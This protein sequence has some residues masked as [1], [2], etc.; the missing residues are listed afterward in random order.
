M[1]IKLKDTTLNDLDVLFDFQTDGE[2]NYL[3]AFTAENPEDKTAYIEKWKN[4]ISDNKKI[5]KTIFFCDEIAGSVGKF[6]LDGKSE[7]TYWIGKKFWGKGI[8][9]EALRL[10]LEIEKTRPIFARTAFDNFG[11]GRVLEKC[12]FKKIGIDKGFANARGKEI[13][14]FIYELK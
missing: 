11:S 8:A 9:T 14:E 7:I 3:A 1:N 6:E 2:A 12:G 4:I 5:A 10:L 13:E